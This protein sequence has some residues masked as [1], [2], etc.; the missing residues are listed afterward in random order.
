MEEASDFD[1]KEAL[2]WYKAKLQLDKKTIIVQRDQRMFWKIIFRQKFDVSVNPLN[3]RF[4]GFIAVRTLLQDRTIVWPFRINNWPWA[5]ML[6]S[7]CC[8]IYFFKKNSP[9]KLK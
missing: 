4:A 1:A 5:R 3:I 8:L 6:T 2:F 7:S 9:M